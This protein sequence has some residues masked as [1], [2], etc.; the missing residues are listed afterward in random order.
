MRKSALTV[1]V[2]LLLAFFLRFYRLAD[3]PLGLFFDPAINGLDTVRLMQR[4]GPVIFFPTNGGREA[5]FMYLLIP[6]VW[7]L[8]TTPLA[9]RILTATISF[10]NVALLFG[11]LYHLPLG[12]VVARP[13]SGS[14][15][16][17][18]AGLGGLALAVSY[19]HLSV[20]RLGQRPLLVPMLAVPFF[21]FFLKGWRGGGKKWFLLAGL[22]LGLE[23]YTYSAARLLPV[24]LLLALLPEFFWGR[25][26]REHA[27]GLALFLLAAL[28]AYAPMG[29]YLVTHPAQFTARAGS[30]MVWNFLDTPGEVA[31]EIGRNTLRALGFF[32]WAGSPNPIFGLPDQPGLSP[33]LAPFLIVG[34]AGALYNWRS[35][36]HRL[37][38]IWW[39]V[40]LL[41]T[42][43]AIEA[44]HPWRMIVAL[45]PT[46]ILIALAPFF[47]AQLLPRFTLHPSPFII[48]HSLFII[49]ILTLPGTYH[50]YFVA[51]E[52]LPA[53]RG[54]YDYSAIAIRDEILTDDKYG[55]P[56]Y[57][58]L[59]RFNDSPLLF[60]LSGHFERQAAL[61]VPPEVTGAL[62]IAPEQNRRDTVW[63]RLQRGQATILPPL[64]P[65]GQQL[66]QAVLA[67]TAPIP[68]AGGGVAA[69]F[70]VLETDPAYFIQQPTQELA[71]DFGPVQLVGA[72]YAPT[73][74]PAAPLPV[75]LFWRANRPMTT[76]YEVLVRLVDDG[77]RAWGNGDG[78]PNDWA[79]PTS[80]WRPGLDEIAAQH[81]ITFTAD[82]PPP[83]RYRLAVSL[84]DAEVGRR[85]TLAGGGD[86]FYVGPLKVPLPPAALPLELRRQSATFI[87]V[88]AQ[89]QT[90]R[91]VARLLGFTLSPDAGRL[92]LYWEA[93]GVPQADYTVFV[94]LLDEAGQLV[95]GSDAPPGYPTSIWSPGEIIPDEHTMPTPLPPGPY[96]LAIGLY[97]QPSGERLTLQL[98]DGREDPQGRLIL[99][100]PISLE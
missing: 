39:L 93:L 68:A 29:W 16:L 44:P 100:Q 66:I 45:P 78:R 56:I 98:P 49:L 58:P 50:A 14:S 90:A 36:F 6:C 73:I 1:F 37:V 30:V 52:K 18:L 10:L 87:E 85:L 5:L 40:G 19:W 60:Y 92:T 71:G 47:L 21:W 8:G 94:H 86:T 11:F 84:F 23:G 74:D 13:L 4:G 88:Q 82:A 80:F 3:Y 89:A 63:V 99:E 26:E 32:G 59:N 2:L 53:M 70:A 97:H 27:I 72:A 65:D 81:T 12:E 9:L 17:W 79:Y 67:D 69:R 28:L 57:L 22:V 83:G 95:A 25:A 54:I 42:I 96:R 24:I 35:L 76:E 20:S 51:W 62:V 31:L 43:V 15:R 64:T 48:H 55:W 33:F 34:L 41:P 61:S 91:P 46:A 75:T 77:L 7:L 38:A